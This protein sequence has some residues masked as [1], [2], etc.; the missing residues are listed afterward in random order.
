[1]KKANRRSGLLFSDDALRA[2]YSD[3]RANAAARRYCRFWMAVFRLGLMPRRWVVL[4]V[5]GRRTGRLTRFPLGMADFEG[6][7]YL[8]PMLGADCNWVRNVRAARGRV[9]LRRRRARTCQL[10]EVPVADRAPILRRYLQKV[11]GARPHLGVDPDA[12]VGEFEAIAPQYPV[13]VINELA[14]PDPL[15]ARAGAGEMP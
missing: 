12:A 6:R 1:M 3:G 15:T 8:V 14:T 5:A 11:P 9:T 4:E 10:L 7:W 2:M 13:F